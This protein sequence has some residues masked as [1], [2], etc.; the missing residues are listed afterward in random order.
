MGLVSGFAGDQLWLC[1]L[2]SLLAHVLQGGWVGGW[3]LSSSVNLGSGFV[4]ANVRLTNTPVLLDLPSS[5][6][7]VVSSIHNLKAVSDS[8]VIYHH[9]GRFAFRVGV[10][11]WE[12]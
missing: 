4:A 7:R 6:L 9:V 10:Q 1:V 2:F 12:L 11:A 8:C 3:K 5:P